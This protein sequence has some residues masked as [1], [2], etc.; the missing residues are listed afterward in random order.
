MMANAKARKFGL[1]ISG[2]KGAASAAPIER[3]PNE[4]FS[5]GSCFLIPV[6]EATIQARRFAGLKPGASTPARRS[7]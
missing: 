6:A 1:Y 4:G 2:W 5:P 7:A 3:V